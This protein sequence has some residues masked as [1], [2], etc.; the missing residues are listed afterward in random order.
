MIEKSNHIPIFFTVDEGYVPWLSVALCSLIKNADKSRYYD[1][2]ILHESISG[3]SMARLLQLAPNEHFSICFVEMSGSIE[4]I[5]DKMCNRL[6]ADYFTMTIF[7]RI[8]IPD[9]FPEYDKGIYI[10]SDIV[11]PGD[12]SRL[13]DED[14]E[15]NLIGACQDHSIVDI[16]ELVAF[17]NKGVG[18]GIQNYINSGV[19]LLNMKGLR[20]ANLSKRF[21]E[22]LNTYHFECI[23][24]D[25]DYINTLC[26]G[27]I[28]YLDLSWDAMPIEGKQPMRNPQ[29]IH[30]NL[31]AKPWCYDDIAYEEYFW[32]YAPDSGYADE[33]A[34]FKRGYSQE[35]KEKDTESLKRLIGRAAEIA[36]A[37]F[38][39]RT[40]FEGGKERRL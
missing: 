9:L 19:L 13:Y 34:A 6:R 2:I 39:F 28:H 35:Q 8:F 26:H 12:I 29:L 11:V 23:A 24:P 27:K 4:G 30:Y 40:V 25:Q 31:F 20:D 22:L 16:P 21:L 14:L 32:R 3:D 5:Q 18:V 38:N 1:I 17:T 36:A 33:I 37:D 7:F 10:D 15:G